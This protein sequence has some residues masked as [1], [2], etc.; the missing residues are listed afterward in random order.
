MNSCDRLFMTGAPGGDSSRAE[1]F[2]RRVNA[3]GV[4]SLVLLV[5]CHRVEAY[6]CVP[7]EL[8]DVFAGVFR[9]C[10][11]AGADADGRFPPT[12]RAGRDVFIYL[13]RLASGLESLVFGEYQILGQFKAAY[14]D[15]LRAGG[16]DGDFDR[17]LR[18][19]ITCAKL[20]RTELDLGAVPTSVCKAGVDCLDR[21]VGIA[22]RRVFVIGS[23]R[24]GSLAAAIAKRRGAASITVCNRS[25]ERTAKLVNALGAEAVDYDARYLV[26][27]RCDIVVSAT[28]SPHVVVERNRLVLDHPTAFLD[29]ATPRDIDPAVESDPLATVVSIATIGELAEG[30]RRERERLVARAMEIIENE[31]EDR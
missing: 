7:V 11:P 6:A 26:I 13:C 3:L 8:R 20:V 5:T 16:V 25:F 14:L 9:E 4:T 21:S 17:L 1:E 12:E 31:T 30:D 27:A 2:R 19:V 18:R 24:T 15:A 10:F 22:G 23:G 29:L 28:A